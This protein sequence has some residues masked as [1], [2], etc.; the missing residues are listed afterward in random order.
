MKLAVRCAL[1]LSWAIS[2]LAWAAWAEDIYAPKYLDIRFSQTSVALITERAAYLFDRK[3]GLGHPYIGP[4]SNNFLPSTARQKLDSIRVN[5]KT[6][7]GLD[8]HW[9]QWKTAKGLVFLTTDGYCDEGAEIYHGLRYK[10]ND[11]DTELPACE[12]ISDIEVIGDQLWLGSYESF[13]GGSGAGSGVRVISLKS[14]QLIA[15]FSPK[16]K[17]M[18]GSVTALNFDAETGTLSVVKKAAAGRVNGGKMVAE[19]KGLLADGYVLFIRH[20]PVTNDVLV[21]TKTALHRIINGKVTE[22]WYLSEQFNSDGQVTLL[23]S[24][25]PQKSNP[26][27]IMA[28]HTKLIDT[29]PI[30]KQLQQSP[31]LVKRLTY[32]YDDEGKYFSIDGKQLSDMVMWDYDPSSTEAA[33]EL[34]NRL[35]LPKK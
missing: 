15:A 27:A 28:R 7:D 33:Q 13:E 20:D 4:L 22:R 30:W 17:S 29:K 8:T 24:L 19:S 1:I 16:Q 18:M 23:A 32:A 25:K 12:S 11:I 10:G 2:S 26:W 31:K 9:D 35:K 34:I 3:V 14:K 5:S 21:L 6:T